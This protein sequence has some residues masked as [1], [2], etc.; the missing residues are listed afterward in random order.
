MT[1]SRAI[2]ADNGGGWDTWLSS[3]D[4]GVAAL[5]GAL[6]LAGGVAGWF[7]KKVSSA[8]A[9][10]QRKAREDEAITAMRALVN[11]LTERV[12]QVERIARIE[13]E[14]IAEISRTYRALP[15][16]IA[17]QFS[18]AGERMNSHGQRLTAMESRHNAL[19]GRLEKLA[20]RV[21]ETATRKELSEGI[22]AITDRLDRAFFS[23]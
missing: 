4:H 13:T 23:K 20:D 15:S 8:F 21:S 22:A 9:A 2:M 6:V 10:G 17:Q 11:G 14:Q 1:E 12:E 7:S 18:Q 19:D 16:E 5:G 3:L